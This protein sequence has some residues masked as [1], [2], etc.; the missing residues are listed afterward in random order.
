VCA[1]HGGDDERAV[2][3][4]ALAH[5]QQPREAIGQGAELL[6]V[7]PDLLRRVSGGGVGAQLN[8]LLHL[9]QLLQLLQT[10]TV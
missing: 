10:Q 3:V 7:K 8:A 4:I 9:L 2:C 1:T 5:V 6:V